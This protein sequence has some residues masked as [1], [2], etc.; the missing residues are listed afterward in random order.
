VRLN[1]FFVG[2]RE[3]EDFLRGSV[4]EARGMK[5]NMQEA[6]V[7]FYRCPGVIKS[8]HSGFFP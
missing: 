3:I 7:I 5:P 4:I 8:H 2:W 6:K 1:R